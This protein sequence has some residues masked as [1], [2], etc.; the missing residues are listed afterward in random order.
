MPHYLL[1]GYL[2]NDFDPSSMTEAMVEE[3]HDMNREMV[4]LGIRRFA[5]GLGASH[6]VRPQAGG[7]PMVTDGPYIESKEMIAGLTIVEVER[8]EDALVWARRT[9]KVCNNTVEV[10]EIFFVPAPPKE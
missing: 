9:A 3:I 7:E 2:P 10:R 1:S 6:T 4:A 5:G 8:L